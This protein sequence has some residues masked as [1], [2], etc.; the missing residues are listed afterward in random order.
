[1]AKRS[2]V[3]TWGSLPQQRTR[4]TRMVDALALAAA[5]EAD[6]FHVRA[7]VE[8]P[9]FASLMYDSVHAARCV[10]CG[11]TVKSCSC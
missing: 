2:V 3:V 9:T 6:A 11:G 5:R 7:W 8:G 1:M 10:F 4:V